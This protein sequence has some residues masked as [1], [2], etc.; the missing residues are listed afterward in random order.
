MSPLFIMFRHYYYYCSIIVNIKNIKEQ[1][2]SD[3]HHS[4]I[5]HAI[6]YICFCNRT[7][8]TL[9]TMTLRKSHRVPPFFFLLSINFNINY[10]L[11]YSIIHDLL[12]FRYVNRKSCL[13]KR[14]SS[15][16]ILDFS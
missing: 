4:L 2:N 10:I 6:N 8:F 16:L 11:H 5:I 12:N 9:I 14:F 7:S 3:S 1:S 15:F 13:L